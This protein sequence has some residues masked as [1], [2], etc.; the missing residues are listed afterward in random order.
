MHC[1]RLCLVRAVTL[2]FTCWL[3]AW[4]FSGRDPSNSSW[5]ICILPLSSNLKKLEKNLENVIHTGSKIF[6]PDPK[7]LSPTYTLRLIIHLFIPNTNYSPRIQSSKTAVDSE[8][9]IH[10]GSYFHTGSKFICCQLLSQEFI[11]TGFCFYSLNFNLLPIVN[12]LMNP[13]L[14]PD[15]V[16]FIPDPILFVPGP[17]LFMPD[18][19]LLMFCW[20]FQRVQ[21]L[22]LN[23]L[24]IWKSFVPDLK[25]QRWAG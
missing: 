21:I 22:L 18:P 10:T 25:T 5:T 1:E 14:I 8:R 12:Y 4:F 2:S 20:L 13:I 3:T 16:L 23:Q 11:H 7:L 6:I 15:P 17:I 19:R 9:S 24:F